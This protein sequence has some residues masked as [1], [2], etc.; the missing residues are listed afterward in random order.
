[1]ERYAVISSSG[2]R[3]ITLENASQSE[4]IE[5]EF[6]EYSRGTDGHDPGQTLTRAHESEREHPSN[7][8]IHPPVLESNAEELQY[9][10]LVRAVI[11]RGHRKS[12]R[13]GVGTLSLFGA[14]MR[15]SLR[16]QRLPLLTTKRVFWRGVVEELLWFLRGS[17]NAH[18]LSARGV[19]IWDE[20]GSRAFLDAQGLEHR[21]V[22]D[23]GPIYG[24][25]WRHFG[26]KYVDCETDYHG[27][28]VDQIRRI[29]ETLR[30]NPD[31]RRMILSAWNPTALPEMALPPCHV[32]AQFYVANGE[33]SCL[34]YQRSCDLGLG[35]PFNIASYALLTMMLAHVT[36]LR[37]GEFIH[38]MG[39]VHVYRNHV[40]ALRAQLLRHPKPFPHLRFRRIVTDID[41]FCPED[42]DLVGYQPHQALKMEMAV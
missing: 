38:T 33:L 5:I 34:M 28:G 42:L 26:A 27:Q 24:F 39:D 12:D 41:D 8:A 10:D 36:G 2:K 37:P 11:E 6:L 9:L 23:L 19:H 14:M 40:D 17:T 31:D 25:Q 30:T 16:D 18:E 32:L 13:T 1:M 29:V 7:A 22:G 20:N 21:A 35:V 15:F 4:Q 3:R